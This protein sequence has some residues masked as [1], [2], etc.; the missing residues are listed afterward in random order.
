MQEAAE[1]LENDELMRRAEAHREGKIGGGVEITYLV[2]VA[3]DLVEEMEGEMIC[4]KMLDC[5]GE[6]PLEEDCAE[7]KEPED[8][9]DDEAEYGVGVNM[10]PI[11]SGQWSKRRCSGDPD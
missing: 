10:E 8:A 11:T 9:V 4:Q 2:P 1:E 7:I 5:Q 6:Y 3:G